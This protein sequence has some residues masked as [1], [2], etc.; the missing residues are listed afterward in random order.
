MDRQTPKGGFSGAIPG[1]LWGSPAGN[2]KLVNL[3]TVVVGK[4]ERVR[5]LS[6]PAVEHH[7]PRRRLVTFVEG[8]LETPVV[9]RAALRPGEQWD[10][11]VIVEQQDTTTVVPPS[12]VV[13]VHS[14]GSLLVEVK[15]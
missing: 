6:E 7:E 15:S 10:G 14:T 11:P 5:F 3:R 2:V 13:E 8:T 4:R 9:P 1:D 12:A